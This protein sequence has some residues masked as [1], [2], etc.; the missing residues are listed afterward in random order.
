MIYKTSTPILISSYPLVKVSLTVF[1]ILFTSST[2]YLAPPFVATISP[3]LRVSVST[4]GLKL[5]VYV[6]LFNL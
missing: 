6:S 3:I 4:F 5:F 2:L 1:S